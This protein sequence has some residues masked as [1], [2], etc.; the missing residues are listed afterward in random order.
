ASG[1]SISQ[2]R[3]TSLAFRPFL[4]RTRAS[5]R[6]AARSQIVENATV[7]SLVGTEPEPASFPDRLSKPLRLESK[8][9]ETAI[10]RSASGR[11]A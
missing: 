1:R 3:M 10:G 6:G 9:I 7:K 8:P 11:I 4:L 5:F 2:W